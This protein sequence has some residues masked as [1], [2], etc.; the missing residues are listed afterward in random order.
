MKLNSIKPK[1]IHARAS[2]LNYTRADGTG[3]YNLT[4]GNETKLAQCIIHVIHSLDILKAF[5][6]TSMKIR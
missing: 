3:S 1:T 5:I 6:K 4:H 2:T